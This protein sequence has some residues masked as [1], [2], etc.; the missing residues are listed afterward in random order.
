MS[1]GRNTCATEGGSG[2]GALLFLGIVLATLTEAIAGIK[3]GTLDDTS[4]L[5]PTMEL[6]CE[7]TQPWVVRDPGRQRLARNP[8]LGA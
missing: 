4:S 2:A 6:W 7:T 3:A 1:A 5:Q 8:P